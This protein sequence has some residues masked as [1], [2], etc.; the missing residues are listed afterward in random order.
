ML[1]ICIGEAT[2]LA[3]EL[4]AGAKAYLFEI[5]LGARTDTGDAEGQVIERC[6]IPVLDQ[7]CIE[8]ALAPLRGPQ[9]QVPP[10]YSALKRDGEPLYKLARRGLT[11]ER[12][13]RAIDIQ[14]LELLAYSPTSLRLRTACSKGTYVR[15]L[16][17]QVAAGLGSCG[18]V[19]LLRREFVAPF[20]GEP[21]QTLEALERG[22]ADPVLLAPDRAV[23]HLPAVH[24]DPVQSLALGHGQT[25]PAGGPEGLVR[26]YDAAGS[27]MGLGQ[28][29]AGGQVR[30]QRLFTGAVA[31]TP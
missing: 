4:L 14:A 29:I 21:M 31:A 25:V 5:Q 23:A 1:P 16:A 3:G 17:E 15:V 30:P 12:P 26:L 22:P 20:E 19:S 8:A 18:H 24:L 13:A 2:K 27:F 7:A 10:M 6:E 28:R 9:L 11:V